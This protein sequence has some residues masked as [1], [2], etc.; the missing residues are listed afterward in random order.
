MLLEAL[1]VPMVAVLVAV[2]LLT[3]TACSTPAEA[4]RTVVADAGPRT[5]ATAASD[6]SVILQWNRI[7]Q[8][9]IFDEN[10]TPVPASGLYF[11]LVSLAVYDAVV[12]I[13]GR[14]EPYAYRQRI[15]RAASSQ[16]A[17]ATAAF[18]VL[19]KHF[20]AS[21]EQLRADYLAS[22]EDIRKDDAFFHGTRAGIEAAREILRAR[23]G[24]GLHDAGITFTREPAPGVW[25][26]TP[27]DDTP[28]AVPWLGFVHPLA[29]RSAT[30]FE[31]PEPNALGSD[32]YARDFE[33]VKRLGDADGENRTAAQ[34]ENALFFSVNAMAQYQAGMRELVTSEGLDIAESA[35]AFALLSTSTADALIA[36]W[37]AKFEHPTWRPVTAIRLAESDGDPRTEA[38]RDWTPLVPTPPYP[39][40][41]SGHACLT[42][43]ASGTFGHLFGA[44][45]MNL[46]LTSAAPGFPEPLTR[47]YDDAAVLDREA[48]DA[49]VWLGI[50]FRSSMGV[51]NTL[52]HEVAEWV[53]AHQFQPAE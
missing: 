28:F 45:S 27:P 50:H 7:A 13:D 36:C 41:A 30:Q 18:V 3:P 46:R 31:L 8:R 6:P 16:V 20:P 4:D 48:M 1:R 51:A 12:A 49:R 10:A 37:R 14:F 52:G 32:A 22:V 44:T 15:E 21:T 24:D 34:T 19:R 17:A 33:E 29:L 35:R 40:F 38:D 53:A 11:G 39:E 43:A 9:T 25:R 42:G 26:P 5:G 2:G 23:E 47:E